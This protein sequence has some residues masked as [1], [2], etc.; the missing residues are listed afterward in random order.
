ME[1][2][3]GVE[4]KQ[5]ASTPIFLYSERTKH[6]GPEIHRV[7][8]N[9]CWPF[10][11]IQP[12]QCLNMY[13]NQPR[14]LRRKKKKRPKSIALLHPKDNSLNYNSSIQNRCDVPNPV[15]CTQNGYQHQVGCGN[16][17]FQVRFSFPNCS[18]CY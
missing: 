10:R 12:H 15:F 4:A 3:L 9:P 7:R 8:P 18:N 6:R 1:T 11:Y 17:P 5:P 2:S 13:N 16:W 14:L